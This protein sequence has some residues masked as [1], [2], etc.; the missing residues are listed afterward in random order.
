[1]IA[2]LIVS[3]KPEVLNRPEYNHLICARP[4]ARKGVVR[5]GNHATT[6]PLVVQLLGP[7]IHLHSTTLLYKRP[8][9]PDIP[10][11]RRG[12]HRDIRIPKDLGHKQLP[13]VGIKICYCLTDF[14]QPNSG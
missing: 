11:F 12:W 13:R 6:V 8:E 4:A 10:A 14:F 9:S 2:W 5:F 7:N 1:M 3:R